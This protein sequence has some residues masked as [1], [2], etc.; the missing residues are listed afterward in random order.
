[1]RVVIPLQRRPGLR[2]SGNFVPKHD[3]SGYCWRNTEFIVERDYGPRM[4]GTANFHTGRWTIV[5]R[6][7]QS[8]TPALAELCRLYWYPLW[9]FTCF[10]GLL[11]EEIGGTVSVPAEIDEEIHA[12]C[13]TLIASE[14]QVGL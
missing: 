8:Q 7:A 13:K 14:G 4:G 5:M 11:H 10:R 9:M 12:R 3:F 2:V 6:A 1:M